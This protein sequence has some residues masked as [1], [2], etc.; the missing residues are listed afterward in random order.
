MNIPNPFKEDRKPSKGET[1]QTWASYATM[2]I[3][4]VLNITLTEKQREALATLIVPFRE[5]FQKEKRKLEE[6][7]KQ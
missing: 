1:D 4:Y 5:W 3:K 6:K 2:G 7:G